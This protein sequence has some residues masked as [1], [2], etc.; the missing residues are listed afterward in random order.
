MGDIILWKNRKK[1][2]FFAK[3]VLFSNLCCFFV[4]TQEII[5]RFWCGLFYCIAKNN[6]S[7]MGKEF[8][9]KVK[10][11]PKKDEKHHFCD[12]QTS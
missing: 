4:I 3:N 6:E 8:F 5:D 2:A 10:I 12:A 7:D 1:G 9:S 11:V